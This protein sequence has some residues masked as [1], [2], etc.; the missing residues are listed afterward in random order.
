MGILL[1]VQS[2][3]IYAGFSLV[4]GNALMGFFLS[5]EEWIL[6]YNSEKVT[7]FWVAS[8]IWLF[9]SIGFFH[10]ILGLWELILNWC[11]YMFIGQL[12]YIWNSVKWVSFCYYTSE[13][14]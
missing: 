8:V 1:C 13:V 10:W 12:K 7:V 9:G 5:L 6:V 2:L 11:M 3:R 14:V 4:S